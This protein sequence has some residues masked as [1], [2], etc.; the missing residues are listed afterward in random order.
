MQA[1]GAKA[2]FQFYPE[3]PDQMETVTAFA[4]KAGFTGGIVIDFPNSTRA[5][6]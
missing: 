2:V 6:K 1:Q 3:T 5:R 4:M